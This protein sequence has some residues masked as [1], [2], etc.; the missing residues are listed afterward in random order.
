MNILTLN[1]PFFKRF[2]RESRSPA[3]AKSGTLYY[4]MWL[5]YATGV[6]E[7]TGFNVKL[8]DAPA[9]NYGLDFINDF[10]KDFRPRLAVIDTSTPS[11][12]NDIHVLEEIKQASPYTLCVLVGRHVS[13]L[14]EET[15]QF[16]SA[17]DGVV[18]GEY[19][20]VVRDLA[21][22]LRDGND[23]GS[24]KG[25]MWRD[26]NGQLIK[27][28]HNMPLIEDLDELPFV[29]RVYERH[30]NIEDY[31]Y[32]HSRH[33]IIVTVTGRGCPHR[34]FYCCYPQTM[35]GCK[36]RLRSPE[37]VAK[38]FIYI[39]D[40]FP[41]VKE[42]MIED[43]TLTVSKKHAL[44]FAEEL[45]RIGNKIPWSAN[46]RADVT[47]LH[48]LKKL[49]KAGC[50]LLCVGYESGDQ[51]ILDNMGKNLRIEDAVEFSQAARK[52][53]IMVH[54]CF[55]VGNPGETLETMEK[56]LEYAKALNPDTAQ[57]YPIMVYPGTRAYEWAKENNYLICSD[58]S[59]WITSEGLHSSV[60][61]MPHLSA[62]ALVNF[63]DRARREFYLRPQYLISKSKQ[64]LRH[65]SEFKRNVM[66][67][68]KLF[69]H[70][71]KSPAH[72]LHRSW[73]RN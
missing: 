65:P 27:N 16:S 57:F 21:T 49:R 52:A 58:Y 72:S 20:Y 48:L 3:V 43:D 61:E 26:E 73:I 22:A 29:S 18:M 34:C 70:V 5:A 68:R 45:I 17:I 10:V 1:P 62:E 14:P 44:R 15:M 69:K 25:L 31:F 40:N 42:I 66:G 9:R 6:L 36:L 53:G 19:D 63:C 13:A 47:D 8:I 59:E 12:Y 38:E 39:R 60:V 46:S 4:P 50:R 11:I 56:T 54:G 55:M 32:G 7:E 64:V 37:S 41:Q 71:L 28:E 51:R 23:L 30:L 35:Y 33:P 67:A 2:S 24:V